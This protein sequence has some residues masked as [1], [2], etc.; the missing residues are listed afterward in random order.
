LPQQHTTSEVVSGAV[1]RQQGHLGQQKRPHVL[2][3]S[4]NNHGFLWIFER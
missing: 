1:A 2:K 4:Y 3:C